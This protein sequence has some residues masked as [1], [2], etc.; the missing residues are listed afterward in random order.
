MAVP[1]RKLLRVAR[2]VPGARRIQ[3]LARTARRAPDAVRLVTDPDRS[4]TFYPG[5]PRKSAARMVADNLGYLLR[6]GEVDE[7]YFMYGLDRV[8]AR[9]V[10]EYPEFR[11][12][13]DRGHAARSPTGLNY[14]CVM[15]DKYL[16]GQVAASFGYPSP[17]NLAFVDRGLVEWIGERERRPLTSLLDRDLDG[18]CKPFAGISSRGAFALRVEGGAVWVDG[19]PSTL[20]GL[21]GLLT[22]RYLVQDRV[23]QHPE[24]AE[25]HPAS[26]N[27]LRVLTVL[28]GDDARVFGVIQRMGRGGSSSDG[29]GAG[30]VGVSVDTEAGRLR[31]RGLVRVGPDAGWYDRH[32]DTGVAFDGRAV[33]S[34]DDVR[35]LS[36]RFH[37]ALPF[38]HTVGWDVAVTPEGPLFIEANE[39]WGAASPLSIEP[40]FRERFLALYE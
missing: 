2:R 8:G 3:R 29:H 35:D 25:L 19:S 31:A 37:E 1:A 22:E 33:P 4:R 11:R 20:D 16:F 15:Q 17:R 38:F 32:P 36:C 28:D 23:V 10:V 18:F 34:F 6:H 5:A 24:V 13:R 14:S 30:G 12:I 39:N 21:R 26:V 40:D 27:T 9:P 7:R